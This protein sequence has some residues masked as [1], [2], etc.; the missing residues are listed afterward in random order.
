MD[1]WMN[2]QHFFS[3]RERLVD[4]MCDEQPWVEWDVLGIDTCWNPSPPVFQPSPSLSPHRNP[5]RLST[6]PSQRQVGVKTRVSMKIWRAK[7]N[8]KKNYPPQKAIIAPTDTRGAIVCSE[9]ANPSQL[10]NFVSANIRVSA[11][12]S[13]LETGLHTIPPSLHSL[14][15]VCP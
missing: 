11:L 5:S 6:A 7:N 10:I 3:H 8:L 12:P 9:H 4:K 15:L 2:K 13:E 14:N 1:K